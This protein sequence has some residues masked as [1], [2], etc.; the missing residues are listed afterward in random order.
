MLPFGILGGVLFGDH[1]QRRRS[2]SVAELTVL[3]ALRCSLAGIVLVA[4]LAGMVSPGLCRADGDEPKST[5]TKTEQ[6]AKSDVDAND[7]ESVAPAVP[8]VWPQGSTV[9]GRVLDHIG[10]PVVNAEVLL[11]GKEQIVVEAD[12]RDSRR[13]WFSVEKQ[14]EEPPSTRTGKNGEFTITR[15]LGDADRLAVITEDPLFWVVSRSSLKQDG[16][17]DIKLPESGSLAVHCDLPGK[18]PKQ[19]VMI[20]LRSF[21]GIV[22]NTDF[23]RFHSSTF[24]LANPGETVFKNLPPGHYSVQ[25]DQVT[26]TAANSI[27]DT[28]ADRRLFEIESAKQAFAE[29][30]RKI[31]KPLSGQV[32]G[33]ENTELRHARLT[34]SHL[35]PEEVLGKDGKRNRMMVAFD[36]IPIT[37]DGRFTTDPIPPGKY[38]VELFAVLASTPQLSSQT[39]DFSGKSSFTVPEEGEMPLVE[40]VAKANSVRDLSKVTDLRLSVVDEDGKPLSKF[41]AMV[42]TAERGST[43][44]IDGGNGL[45]F[46]GAAQ[47]FG[48]SVLEVLVRADGYASTIARF[49]GEQQ[50]K[51]SKGEAAITLRR[52]QNVQLKFNLPK[53]MTW[54]KGVLPEVYFE[55]MQQRVR[56][57]WQ[58]V[59]R[60]ADVV[61]DFNMLNLR[62]VGPG[63][64]QFW[65]TEDSSPF[66]VAIHSPGFLQFFETGPFTFADTKN[67][68]LEIDVP[69]PATL[70]VS[71]EPGEQPG[72]DMPFKSAS[73]DVLWNLSG[74]SYL[75]LTSSAAT[76]LSPRLKLTDLAPGIYSVRVRTQP[77]EESQPIPGTRINAG[78]YR[79]QTKLT[80]KS[81]QSE[82]INFRSTPFDPNAFRGSRTAKL[83]IRDPDGQPAKDRNV[84]VDYYD[85]HYGAQTVFSG[86][87]PESGE[88]VLTDITDKAK[89]SANQNRAY[90]VR[91]DEKLL[92]FFGFN[93]EEPTEE[94]EFFLAPGTG[95]MAPDIELT[96]LATGA[97]IRLNSLREKV[98]L[99]EFWA[100]WCGPCQEPMKKLNLLGNG[101][102][103]EWKDRV[104]IVPI[105]IDSEQSRVKLHVQQRG[106]TGLEHFWSGGDGG[107]DFESPAA[108]AFGVHGVPEAV[109]ISP[110][111]R[112]LW[113]G[114]PLN[115]IDGKDIKSRIEDALGK[116]L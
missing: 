107:G 9:E 34:I 76:S 2:E 73:L 49:A 99:L 70:D 52:G 21:D 102:S 5:A 109:M 93:K 67:W 66:H 113:R 28:P 6:V 94:F 97:A 39:S 108:R 110:D 72:S 14:P 81:G 8:K 32:R 58:S 7:T 79:D 115:P 88:I 25:R 96:S 85:G 16:S 87:V 86:T 91:I 42:Q 31:G 63:Q 90:T 11:L 100:T 62:E 43:S 114:H 55:E 77:K 83:H 101:Q 116:K 46:L 57:M 68:T 80:L 56:M 48:G 111:G 4:V 23:L 89:I 75:N 106:W 38:I 98:V 78:I 64:F 12:R 59:N 22:W 13:N 17:I 26:K 103:V 54:P 30:E 36:V 82:Q 105:S 18:S 40:I 1:S 20:E 15:K 44:W 24:S 95:D 50:D 3:R 65:V 41:Q 71:F 29:F 60:R 104:V 47:Q 74:N 45:V 10:V 112:I 27:V 92:G 51:L 53:G 61:Y 35:G 84:T 33:L 19:P 37:A 69:R